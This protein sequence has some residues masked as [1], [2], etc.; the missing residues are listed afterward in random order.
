MI[1]RKLTRIKSNVCALTLLIVSS[2]PV[3]SQI[4]VAPNGSDSNPGTIER[5][6]ESLQKAQG[7]ASPGDTACVRGGIYKVRQDQISK[8]VSNLFACVTYLDKSGTAGH[9]I[10]Y[11]AYPGERPILDFSA[12]NRQTREWQGYMW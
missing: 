1:I 5:P 7:S 9:T 11:W 3:F 10:K 12:V 6:L 2:T 4:Y 8:V